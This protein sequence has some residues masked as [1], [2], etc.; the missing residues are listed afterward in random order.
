MKGKYK[1]IVRNNKLHYE[2]EIKRNI[3]IIQGDSATGKT[4][5]INM[6]RQAENL[7]ESSGVDVLSNVPCRILEGVS[8]KLILQNTAGT[9]F[10]IDEE[11]A[12]INTEE[13]AAEVRGSDNYFVLIT[14]E[15]L[16]NLPYSVE[17]IYGLYASG[18]YQNTKKIYQQM[19]R[20]YSDIQELPIKPELFIVEDSNSGYEFFKAVSDE[21]NLECESAGGKSNIFSKIKNVKN[22]E[23]CVIADGAAIGPEM[24]GLYEISHKKK[25]IHLYLP[26][27]FEWIVLKSGLIDDREI[28]KILETPELFIDS[29]KYFSWERFFTNLLIEKT[30]NS[31]LQYRKSA[32]NKTYLHSKNKEKI[33]NCIEAIQW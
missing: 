27:S 13:F 25:N 11:N 26:E 21:R 18:R 2:F 1:V 32:I 22:R 33:L 30:K 15:N 8:W 14:R 10:F 4:T 16:Y 7:G 23:V 19:Y 12:F 9:I 28:R 31:Y 17:E 29:K 5:L 24:N 20:I 6:L 3:T